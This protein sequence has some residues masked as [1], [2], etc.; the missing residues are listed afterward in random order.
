M[1]FFGIG[2]KNGLIYVIKMLDY[3]VYKIFLFLVVVFDGG[4]IVCID[5][6]IV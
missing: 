2:C 1:G 4:K 6:Y 5:K 3:E